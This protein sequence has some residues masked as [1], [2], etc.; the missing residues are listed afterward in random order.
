MALFEAAVQT[1]EE[2]APVLLVCQEMAAPAA[3]HFACPSDHPFAMALLLTKPGATT[4]AL[5]S[6]QLGARHESV[7]WP[8]LP[9]KLE[10]L[11]AGNFGAR[12]L[13]LLAALAAVSHGAT[14]APRTFGFP[15]SQGSCLNVSMTTAG[16]RGAAHG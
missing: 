14:H 8:Q 6:I 13:P 5:A 15:L 4:N 11:F 12:M 10:A 7:G 9:G 3:L 1:A 16:A 2:D